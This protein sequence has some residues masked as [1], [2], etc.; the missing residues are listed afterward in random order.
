[1]MKFKYA[2][3]VFS[4]AA[5]GAAEFIAAHPKIRLRERVLNAFHGRGFRPDSETDLSVLAQMRDES[6]KSLEN[7]RMKAPE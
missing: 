6:V 5:L 2:P 7:A 3:I 1:M 4:A